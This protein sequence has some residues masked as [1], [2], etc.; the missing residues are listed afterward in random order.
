MILSTLLLLGM[1]QSSSSER[2]VCFSLLPLFALTSQGLLD[3]T[4]SASSEWE[5]DGRRLKGA[6]LRGWVANVHTHK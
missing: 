6:D 3:N 5:E 4:T 1:P 2:T